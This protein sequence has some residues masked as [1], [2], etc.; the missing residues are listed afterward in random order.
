MVEQLIIIC[1]DIMDGTPCFFGTRVP[2]D[3][4]F[5]NLR[6]GLSI[7]EIVDSYPT[8]TKEIAEKV[9]ANP[10]HVRRAQAEDQAN[11]I[12]NL[13]GPGLMKDVALVLLV[14]VRPQH[15]ARRDFDRLGRYGGGRTSPHLFLS[16][17]YAV[18]VAILSAATGTAPRRF[19][20]SSSATRF[21]GCSAIC[22]ITVRR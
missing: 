4:L 14:S 12:V 11:G 20:G 6:D 10:E 9:L 19:Q 13:D 8:L 15:L 18:A 21:T 22:D 2:I 16:G 17:D 1:P 7:D 3:V 5:D